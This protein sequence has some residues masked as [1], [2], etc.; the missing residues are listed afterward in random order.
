[1]AILWTR[2]ATLLRRNIVTDCAEA[3]AAFRL[4]A[5]ILK[6]RPAGSKGPRRTP[7]GGASCNIIISAM[8]S[9]VTRPVR[10][11]R[12]SMMPTAGACFCCNSLN[13]CSHVTRGLMVRNS[14]L[15]ASATRASGPS[16]N[17]VWPE[18]C[19]ER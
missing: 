14:A 1:M 7:F 19:Y 9:L 18:P 6:R 11:P 10:P 15:M 8:V 3:T 16:V 2:N 13:A 12:A 17:L 4:S 5:V